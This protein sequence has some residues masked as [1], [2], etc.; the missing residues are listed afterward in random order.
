MLLQVSAIFENESLYK[1]RHEDCQ[2]SAQLPAQKHTRKLTV[3]S[4]KPLKSSGL[5]AHKTPAM[6]PSEQIAHD[7]SLIPIQWH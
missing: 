5:S 7:V 4:G 6:S 2:E 3:Q 1:A